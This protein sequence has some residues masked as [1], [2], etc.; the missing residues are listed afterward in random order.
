MGLRPPAAEAE[1]ATNGQRQMTQEMRLALS[2]ESLEKARRFSVVF[3]LQD[4][5]GDILGSLEEFGE[6]EQLEEV[7]KLLLQIA[8]GPE[9]SS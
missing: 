9:G 1:P 2:P 7:E 6:L 8:L 4:E 5:N 3:Q